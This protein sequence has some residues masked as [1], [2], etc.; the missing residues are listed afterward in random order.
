MVTDH[1]ARFSPEVLEFIPRVVPFGAHVHDPFAGT[2]E[3]LGILC[4]EYGWEFSGTELELS[5]IE[6]LRVTHGNAT[7]PRTYPKVDH[8][9]IVTSPV[10]PNGVADHWHARDLSRR[11]N[12]RAS[13]GKNE[14]QDRELHIDNMGR[15]GYRNSG[16]NSP[17]RKAYWDIARRSVAC[18]DRADLVVVNVSDYLWKE[19]REPVVDEWHR[20]LEDAGWEI[21]AVQ[22][23][24]TPRDRSHA[25]ADVRVEAEAILV[26]RRAA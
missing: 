4:D 11:R 12:Y 20:L 19:V 24:E 5:F 23:V 14:G 1:P 6:D 2:G 3:R 26:G 17:K 21:E 7:D 15:Y 18:W 9:V 10:Y 13:V 25:N 22:S 8:W 16:P